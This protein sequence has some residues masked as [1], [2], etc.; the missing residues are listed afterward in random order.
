[1]ETGRGRG[2]DGR[3][4]GMRRGGVLS[5]GGGGVAGKGE[6]LNA[7]LGVRVGRT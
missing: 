4:T 1:M 2:V 7:V 6:R 3:S 5:G